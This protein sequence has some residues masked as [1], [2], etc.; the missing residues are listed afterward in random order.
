MFVFA[1]A[2]LAD[3]PY[4]AEAI[5]LTAYANTFLYVTIGGLV[6][7]ALTR[8][9]MALARS[10]LLLRQ[11][12]RARQELQE[13]EEQFRALA[14]SSATGVVIQ[15]DGHLVY[16]NPSFAGMARCLQR[17]IFGVSLWAFFSP[18][19]DK[20]L[21]EQLA[22]R[23]DPA[24]GDPA[25]PNQLLFKPLK[26]PPLWCEVVVAD[27]TYRNRAAIVAN[28]LDVTDRVKAQ[29]QVKQERDFSNSIIDAADAIIIALDE[30][31]GIV[32][33]NAAGERITEFTE[34]ELRGLTVWDT[35][36]PE[37]SRQET[38]DLFNQIKHGRTAGHME[39][40]WLTKSAEERT[41]AWRWMAQTDARGEFSGV[42][43]VGI[44]VTQQ[45]ILERQAMSTERLRSLGQIAGGV[46]HDL[47]NTLAGIMGPAEL[48]L[49]DA[50]D[51]QTEKRLSAIVTAAKRG[52][53]T[54][55][56]IQ[57]FSKARTELDRQVFDLHALVDEVVYAL[58]P[59]WR[60]AAQ[61]EGITIAITHDVPERV[62]VVASSGEIGNV[63]T[64]L[65]VNAC[66]AMPDGGD[67][68]IT[69]GQSDDVVLF[70][71][72][73]TGTGMSEE[74][75][76]NMFQPF[77]STKGGENSGLGLAIIRGIILRHGGNIEVDSEP[78][79]GTTFTVSLPAFTT[80]VEDQ[81]TESTEG[82]QM[83]ALRFL[84][85][86][87]NE[88]IA[89]F[90]GAVL[91]RVGHEVVVVYAG[92][93]AL[94]QLRE[95]FFDVLITDYG[96]EGVSGTGLAREAV[97]LHPN[98]KMVLITGWDVSPSEFEDFHATLKKPFTIDQLKET[99]D[100]L[101]EQQNP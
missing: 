72:A 15:Q 10:D 59:H 46:A 92:E 33:F 73:D 56:R 45:R 39:D 18:E 66:E 84:V 19:D 93:E 3:R 75:Q 79:I 55:G 21:E 26:G 61:R 100:G 71:V 96:M 7:V 88:D 63:L 62:L 38:M 64:N 85:V 16:G 4:L 58:R 28:V 98:I 67:I 35:L 69:G 41:I 9:G 76:A 82:E 54:V 11:N 48:L 20:A 65:I 68:T 31:G 53:E 5:P 80:E 8:M 37:D 50:D 51:P 42:I 101:V 95:A 44:D 47:N 17:D 91:K 14:E 27:A 1:Y 78:G 43:V 6:H 22:R 94:T 86:D 24:G 60:D 97:K 25:T 34:A 99:V 90:A 29:S 32:R 77:F 52:A 89:D 70:Q 36:L 87:D 57:R 83:D 49:L 12:E 74:T 30:R 81:P 2:N 23:R 40:V 13:S